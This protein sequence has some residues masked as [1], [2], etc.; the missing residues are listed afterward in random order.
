MALKRPPKKK[1]LSKGDIPCK[2][3]SPK[4]NGNETR[5]NSSDILQNNWCVSSNVS[6]SEAKERLKNYSRLKERKET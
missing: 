2:D 3:A 1:K 4:F 6:V 5:Q